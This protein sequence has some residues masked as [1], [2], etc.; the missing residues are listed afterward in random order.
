M[1]GTLTALQTR[2]LAMLA[3]V[4]PAWT[5]T[6]GGALCGFHL[7]HRTTR[8][9]DLFW[10][11][12][13]GFAQEPATCENLL[14]AGGLQVDVLQRSPAFVRL[15]CADARETVVVDL[16]AEPVP[17][18]E[19]PLLARASEATI[20]V[21]TEYEIF[22]NK[23][24]ALLHRAEVRDLVD[25]RALLRRG[26]DLV[27]GLRDAARKDGGFSPL[28]L[29]HLLRSFPVAK[30]ATASGLSASDAADLAAFRDD[31]EQRIAKLTRP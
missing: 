15:Q 16:V 5:L 27:H 11:G 12:L 7:Q 29:G 18:I 22:V 19:P 9:L 20:R 1:T 3:S 30:L 2:V 14:R 28:M 23:L 24:G 21:D 4:Q 10:H 17:A 25:L 8:D 6:G 13:R 26:A 31:L